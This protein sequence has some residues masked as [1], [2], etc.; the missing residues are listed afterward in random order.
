MDI[1]IAFNIALSL[2][3]F[4][5]GWV[6][7]SL[8][9]SIKFLQKSDTE[10]ADKMQKIEVLVAG[11]YVKKDDIDKLSNAIFAKLDRIEDKLDGKVDK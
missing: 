9:D 7:N 8:R 6:L 1:Q 10:L 3:A 2:V 11:V 5:G 4:L